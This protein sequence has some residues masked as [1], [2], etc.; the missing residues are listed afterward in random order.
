M[1]RT[2][3]LYHHGIKG[4]KWGVRRFQNK[5][6]S[7]TNAGKKRYSDSTVSTEKVTSSQKSGLSSKQKKAIKVGVAVAGT[8]IAAY[9]A[10]KVGQ[11]VKNKQAGKAAV[12]KALKDRAELTAWVEETK[13]S[14]LLDGVKSMTRQVGDQVWTYENNPSAGVLSREMIY[15]RTRW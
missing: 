2:D 3:E 15:D 4:M 5:N 8:A 14:G 10:Y 1:N 13:R 11:I 7:L 6:G 12:E 9:G